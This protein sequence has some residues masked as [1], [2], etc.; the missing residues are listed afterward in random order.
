MHR[1][2]L[3]VAVLL[4]DGRCAGEQGRC[5]F[6]PRL[7]LLVISPWARSNFVDSSVTSQTSIISF[8]ENNWNLGRIAGSADGATGSIASMFNF[9]GGQHGSGKLLLDPTTGQPFR[10]GDH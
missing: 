3:L 10:H 8:V 1:A 6:G 7:P 9:S 4:R 2:E 5:G